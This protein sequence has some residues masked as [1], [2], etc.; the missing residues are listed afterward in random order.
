MAKH[1]NNGKCPK[2]AEFLQTAQPELRTWFEAEQALDPEVHV[3]CS[4][5]SKAAQEAA[6]EGGFSKASYGL[7]PHNYK[8]SWAIDLFFIINGTA[9]WVPIGMITGAPT[10]RNLK[11]AHTSKLKAGRRKSL[12]TLTGLHKKKNRPRWEET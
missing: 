4:D 11:T 6:K 5:R 10:T 2:C 1:I 9:A 12:A 8:T 3:S 7:S